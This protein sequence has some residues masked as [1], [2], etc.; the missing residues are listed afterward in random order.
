MELPLE[1]FDLIAQA[2]NSP[3]V[4][5]N[6]CLTSKKFAK[7][8]SQQHIKKKYEK[9][10]T[11][12]THNHRCTEYKL[13]GKLHNDDGPAVCYRG[14]DKISGEFWSGCKYYRYGIPHR[15]DGP[16]VI[17][18]GEGCD[19]ETGIYYFKTVK[20]YVNGKLHRIGG[21]AKIQ[22]EWNDEGTLKES[23]EYYENGVKIEVLRI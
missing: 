10:W 3:S 18:E 20:Y 2:S 6:L 9:Q 11:V 7:F 5:I 12:I 8:F 13:F 17:E 1:L 16:A 21:P 19:R 15:E 23:L 14:K 4:Y 22:K